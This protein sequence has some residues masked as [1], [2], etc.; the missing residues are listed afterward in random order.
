ESGFT[1]TFGIGAV[2][3]ALV[4]VISWLGLRGGSGTVTAGTGRTAASGTAATGTAVTDKAVT[5][6]PVAEAVTGAVTE[7]AAATG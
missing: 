6:K 7:K 5:E 2:A 1:L 4:A 3:F